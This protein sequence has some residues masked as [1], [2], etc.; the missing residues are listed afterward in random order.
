MAGNAIS[1]DF[2]FQPNGILVAISMHRLDPLEIA[3]G[4]N[5]S[6]TPSAFM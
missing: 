5:V 6:H 4:F 3:G 1:C 2:D